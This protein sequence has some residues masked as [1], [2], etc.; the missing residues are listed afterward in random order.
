MVQE[1]AIN[2]PLFREARG[3][4]RLRS[5]NKRM[6]KVV[7]LLGI[8]V[9]YTVLFVALFIG[10]IYLFMLHRDGSVSYYVVPFSRFMTYVKE[11]R[12]RQVMIRDDGQIRAIHSDPKHRFMTA[13]PI[14]Y[15]KLYE[16]LDQY[17]VTYAADRYNIIDAVLPWCIAIL[18]FILVVIVVTRLVK[19]FNRTL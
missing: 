15:N 13:L 9:K 18:Y 10:A 1:V 17:S 11:G 5:I 4:Q 14:G 12:I 6:V 19:W 16:I 7:R 3:T 8:L 2:L